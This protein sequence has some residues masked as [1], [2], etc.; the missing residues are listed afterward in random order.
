M[1]EEQVRA[2]LL[3]TVENEPSLMQEIMD[4]TQPVTITDDQPVPVTVG[5]DDQPG[6]S[7]PAPAGGNPKLPWCTCTFCREMPQPEENLCCGKQPQQ[8][9]SRLAVKFTKFIIY[10]NVWKKCIL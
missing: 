9:L 4:M 10:F 1:S 2:L 6:G 7:E 3:R 8:C 5:S